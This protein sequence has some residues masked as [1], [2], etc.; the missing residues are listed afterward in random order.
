MKQISIVIPVF[1]EELNIT[2]LIK[3]IYIAIKNINIEFEI[4]IIDDASTDN[5]NEL[6]KNY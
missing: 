4:I 5:S 3:E 6:I 2:I 1:N